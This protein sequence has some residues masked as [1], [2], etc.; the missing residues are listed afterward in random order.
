MKRVRRILLKI[1]LLLFW[2][3]THNSSTIYYIYIFSYS[4]ESSGIPTKRIRSQEHCNSQRSHQ[5]TK[6]LEHELFRWW[7]IKKRGKTTQS[8]IVIIWGHCFLPGPGCRCFAVKHNAK[9]TPVMEGAVKHFVYWMN[10]AT[11]FCWLLGSLI[12]FLWCTIT[13]ASA[14]KAL[15]AL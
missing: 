10:A 3:L 1:L 12:R 7:G 13:E 2:P 15:F 14:T 11:A 6:P 4:G 9:K 5:N 8:S